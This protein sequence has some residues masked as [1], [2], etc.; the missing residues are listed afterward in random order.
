MAASEQWGDADKVGT[1]H[2]DLLEPKITGTSSVFFLCFFLCFFFFFLNF[3]YIFSNRRLIGVHTE[4][5]G[6]VSSG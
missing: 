2:F 4:E 1:F 3:I 5:K 6:F